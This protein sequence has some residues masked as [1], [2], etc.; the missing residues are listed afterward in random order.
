MI[1]IVAEIVGVLLDFDDVANSKCFFHMLLC[2][3]I[4]DQTGEGLVGGDECLEFH[5]RQVDHGFGFDAR[6]IYPEIKFF[7]EGCPVIPFDTIKFMNR[8][9]RW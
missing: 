9:Y 7:F 4:R 3:G 1:L 8:Y 2:R 5:R 6:K